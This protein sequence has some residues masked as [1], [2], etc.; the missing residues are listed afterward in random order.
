MQVGSEIF[1][2]AC[3]RILKV[4]EG[5]LQSWVSMFCPCH[6]VVARSG[7]APNPMTLFH[8]VPCTI[9]MLWLIAM[10]WWSVMQEILHQSM[11]IA[12]NSSVL[13]SSFPI[14]AGWVKCFIDIT[15]LSWNNFWS[16]IIFL[17]LKYETYKCSYILPD[18][19]CTWPRTIKQNFKKYLD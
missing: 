13:F 15:W 12:Q 7:S 4:A 18:Q 19:Y 6:V 1:E 17:M 16:F 3:Y 2:F 11:Y 5:D 14:N 9:C 10:I 8:E